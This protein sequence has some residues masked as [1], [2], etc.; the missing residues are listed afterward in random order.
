MEQFL[1]QSQSYYIHRLF[2]QTISIFLSMEL[3]F[4][5]NG[6]TLLGA[7][8]CGGMVLWDDDIDIAIN[9]KDRDVLNSQEFLKRL[10]WLKMKLLKPSNLYYKIKYIDCEEEVFIDICLIDENGCDLRKH[11]HKRKYNEGE[12]YPLRAVQFSSIKYPVFIPYKSEEYLDRIFPNWRT[13]AVIYNHSDN[14]KDK[15]TIPLTDEINIPVKY[16]YK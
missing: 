14:K 1:T 11:K 5:A 2:S 13:T 9:L 8:R 15:Q 12:I 3:D 16:Y 4:W 6:G 7:L 10:G